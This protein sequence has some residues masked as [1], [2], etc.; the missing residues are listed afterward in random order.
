MSLDRVFVD[1]N[2]AGRGGG[3]FIYCIGE[4]ASLTAEM[5]APS[6][7]FRSSPWG[8]CSFD[9]SEESARQDHRLFLQ[10]CSFCPEDKRRVASE[11]YT[12]P[13]WDTITRNGVGPQVRGSGRAEKDAETQAA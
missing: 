3:M 9:R 11:A 10:V 5:G 4:K 1:F 6:P 2:Q 12:V 13:V 7:L 8:V